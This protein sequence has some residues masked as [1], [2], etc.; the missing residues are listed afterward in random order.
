MS[1][2][3]LAATPTSEVLYVLDV[4]KDVKWNQLEAVLQ[5]CGI[6]RSSGARTFKRGKAEYR[7]W[8]IVLEN[9]EKGMSY[10]CFW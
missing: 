6:V 5:V 2:P 10:D 3:P 1:N 9:V 4:P 8:T 7:S